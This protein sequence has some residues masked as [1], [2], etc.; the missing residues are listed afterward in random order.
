MARA[1]GQ[2]PA[3]AADGQHRG[4]GPRN[5]RPSRIQKSR[6][7]LNFRFPR[8]AAQRRIS[9]GAGG[10]HQQRQG[11]PHTG[12]PQ[13]VI[14][15]VQRAAP[16]QRDRLR[17]CLHRSPHGGQAV[18]VDVDR[19]RP[20]PAPAGQRHC[21]GAGPD[22]E[23]RQI[24]NRSP[25]CSGHR[26][27]DIAAKRPRRKPDGIALQFGAPRRPPAAAQG[28]WPHPPAAAH[29]KRRKVHRRAARQPAAAARCFL[30]LPAGCTPAAPARL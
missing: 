30:P 14:H 3:G 9:F 2:Q 17:P 1:A 25:H 10:R 8:H 5:F 12:Q 29:P 28:W 18:K 11:G 7:I 24:K 16:P 23:R 21:D 27:R 15:R 13:R 6:H 19:P 4:A 22:Q 20:K 26:R